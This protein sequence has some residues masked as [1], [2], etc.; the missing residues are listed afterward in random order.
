M[1]H[2]FTKDFLSFLSGPL[3]TTARGWGHP[4]SEWQERKYQS[5]LQ[6][7]SP[8]LLLSARSWQSM[9]LVI[10][11]L[12]QVLRRVVTHL[13]LPASKRVFSIISDS[14]QHLALKM[15][16]GGPKSFHQIPGSC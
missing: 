6:A 7:P 13:L 11:N 16:A 3:Q 5:V 10:I 8:R 1:W 4:A 15:G 12:A 2:Q 9:D 14:L